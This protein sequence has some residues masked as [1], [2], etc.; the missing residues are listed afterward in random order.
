MFSN[1][2]I[3]AVVVGAIVGALA[4]LAMPGRQGI[5]VLM[6][7]LLGI[8]GAFIGSWLTAQFGYHNAN[9]GFAILPFVVGVAAAAGLIALYVRI[10][11][12]RGTSVHH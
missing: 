3:A 5:G 12:R 1:T 4:R 8:V 11:G 9:G 6:T 7:V 2:I 10:S